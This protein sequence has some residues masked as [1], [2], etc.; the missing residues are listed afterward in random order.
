MSRKSF[1][2]ILER[3][4]DA[5]NQQ[6][7]LRL[8]FYGAIPAIVLELLEENGYFVDPDEAKSTLTLSAWQPTDWHTMA[9]HVI[10]VL[11]VWHG[12][13]SGY[14]S[15]YGTFH[16]VSNLPNIGSPYF[17]S[18]ATKSPQRRIGELRALQEKAVS[19]QDFEQAARLRDQIAELKQQAQ[20]ELRRS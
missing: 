11:T 3:L 8:K 10:E 18:P 1:S 5:E 9:L 6:P 14:M 7:V 13:Y 12:Q 16:I 17:G 15:R 4:A 19:D 20:P 2:V